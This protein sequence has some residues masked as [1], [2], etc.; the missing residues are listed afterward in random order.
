MY[1]HAHF[2]I[3]IITKKGK[4]VY[5]IFFSRTTGPISIKLGTIHSR[6]KGIQVRSNEGLRPFPG[7]DNNEIGKIH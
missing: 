7:G 5:K 1:D 4:Y 2:L 6:V 3:E